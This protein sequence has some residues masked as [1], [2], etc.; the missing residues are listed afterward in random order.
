MRIV[1]LILVMIIFANTLDG[2]IEDKEV[3]I[4]EE[5]FENK[6]IKRKLEEKTNYVTLILNQDYNFA[7]NAVL[8]WL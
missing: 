6:N 8:K 7:I 1:G 5:K 3:Q 2:V 4:H